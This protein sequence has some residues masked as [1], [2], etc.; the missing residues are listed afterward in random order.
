M[1]ATIAV[2]IDLKHVGK[3]QEDPTSVLR[4]LSFAPFISY[5]AANRRDRGRRDLVHRTPARSHLSVPAPPVQG[6]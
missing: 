5:S 4:F 1:Q 2:I 3:T 6:S